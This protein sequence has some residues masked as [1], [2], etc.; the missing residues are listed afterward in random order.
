MP[1][2]VQNAHKHTYVF[3]GSLLQI[4]GAYRSR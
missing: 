1:D 3:S 2:I 4:L